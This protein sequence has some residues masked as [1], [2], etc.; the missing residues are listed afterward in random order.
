MSLVHSRGFWSRRLYRVIESVTDSVPNMERTTSASEARCLTIR[1]ASDWTGRPQVRNTESQLGRPRQDRACAAARS[2]TK[3]ATIA[4]PPRRSG[5][6]PNFG[7]ARVDMA[8]DCAGR[9]L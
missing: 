2:L 1:L 9:I 6:T 8:S 4:M 5:T 3:T 7:R